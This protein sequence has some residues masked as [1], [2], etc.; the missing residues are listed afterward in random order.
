MQSLRWSCVLAQL[1]L[2]V[3]ACDGIIEPPTEDATATA[4]K[5]LAAPGSVRAL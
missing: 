5:A 1:S 4:G 3:V 2:A